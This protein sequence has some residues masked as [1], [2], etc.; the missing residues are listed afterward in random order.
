[1]LANNTVFLHGIRGIGTTFIARKLFWDYYNNYSDGIEY[2]AWIHYSNDLVHSLDHAFSISKMDTSAAGNDLYNHTAKDFSTKKGTIEQCISI[3]DI[4]KDIR[5]ECYTDLLLTIADGFENLADSD[6]EIKYY[7]RIIELLGDDIYRKSCAYS[8]LAIA[9]RNNEQHEESLKS[10]LQALKLYSRQLEINTD[11]AMA[12]NER[13]SLLVKQGKNEEAINEYISLLTDKSFVSN[14]T[15]ATDTDEKTEAFSMILK[16]C[17]NIGTMYSERGKFELSANIISSILKILDNFTNIE[18]SDIG[19][20]YNTLA[21]DYS[22]MGNPHEAFNTFLRALRTCKEDT[23]SSAIICANLGEISL[24]MGD[25]VRSLNFYNKA[26]LIFEKNYGADDYRVA[27]LLF[28]I[29]KVYFFQRDFDS[30]LNCFKRV[31]DSFS[32]Y[33]GE[34]HENTIE[35]KKNN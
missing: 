10:T 24:G 9:Y 2:L 25:P 23:I 13:I 30:S 22:N 31:R 17:I 6:N 3:A 15:T 26:L 1:M 21:Y 28:D 29:A 33:Y 19:M 20:A 35:V 32:K 18:I 27:E 12:V 4:F 34:R 14:V 11:E 8:N 7:T 5:D 16:Y